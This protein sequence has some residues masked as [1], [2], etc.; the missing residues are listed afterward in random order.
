MVKSS[1][2]IFPKLDKFNIKFSKK[3]LIIIS[4]G[5]LILVLIL[6]FRKLINFIIQKVLVFLIIF[7]LFLSLTKNMIITIIGSILVFLL[8]NLIFSYNK[9]I[10]SFEDQKEEKKEEKKDEDKKEN[11]LEDIN[12]Y[13]DLLENQPGFIKNIFEDEK[14][15]KS[16]QGIQDLLGKLNGGIKLK[17]DDLVETKS[18]GVDSNKYADDKTP[19][20][21]KIAQKEAFELIDTV[22]ALNDTITTLSPVLQ[23]G[24][25]LMDMFQNISL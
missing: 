8:I 5:I 21:L 7:L 18:L 15:K 9:T 3:Q 11:K 6:A 22:N 14:V 17:D 19:T 12:K 4:I 20:P 16:A 25:K 23:E 13:K 1:K 2:M 10:E 24:K